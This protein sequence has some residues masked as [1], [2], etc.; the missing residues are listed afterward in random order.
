[1]SE[2]DRRSGVKRL[3]VRGFKAVRYCAVLKAI[4]INLLRA[5]SVRKA[6]N[7]EENENKSDELNPGQANFIIK[8]R[9]LYVFQC[10]K[11]LFYWCKVSYG[12][13]PTTS[14]S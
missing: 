1:M 2:Y 10:L 13:L 5:A 4:G 6:T 14:C 12:H 11:D 3:R 9:F 8:E 7:P